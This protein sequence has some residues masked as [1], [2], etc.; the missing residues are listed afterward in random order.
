MDDHYRI[1]DDD[2]SAAIGELG[3]HRAAGRLSGDELLARTAAVRRARTRA[4]LRTVLGDLP[5]VDRPWRRAWRDRGWRAHAGVFAVLT[6]ATILLWLGVRDR[7]PLP[8]DYGADY[9]WPLW[10]ALLWAALLLLHYV[11]VG[12]RR[13]PRGPAHTPP[14]SR[15][16]PGSTEPG[17]TEPGADL[18]SGL[19]ARERE[20]LAMIGQGYANKDIARALF[21]SER[22]ART[23]VSNILRKLDLSSRTQAALVASGTP[24]ARPAGAGRAGGGADQDGVP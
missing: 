1:S 15:T 17:S 7:D 5:E 12:V 4:D 19:T 21:I 20:V 18:L 22:T 10:L 8:R 11:V 9:W 13:A 16:E 3:A 2:R 14:A 23:H 6:T 24:P